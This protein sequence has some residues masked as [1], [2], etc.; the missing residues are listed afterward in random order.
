MSQVT[1]HHMHDAKIDGVDQPVPYPGPL[2]E[3]PEPQ[4]ATER[5]VIE[6][7]AEWDMEALNAHILSAEARVNKALDTLIMLRDARELKRR[8]LT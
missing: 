5:K 7:L 4:C 3:C 1:S 8:D 2:Y 6:G